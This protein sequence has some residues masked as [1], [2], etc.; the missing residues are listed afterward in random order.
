MRVFGLDISKDA[1]SCV[2]LET[3]F[4]RFEIRETYEATIPTDSAVPVDPYFTATGLLES[5]PGKPGRL[6]TSVPVEIST[7]RNIQVATKDKKSIR[8]ALNFELEDDLPFESDNLHYA[9]ATL[10]SAEPGSTIHVGA[11]KKD[12][13]ELH[14]QKLHENHIDPEIITTDAWAY[15]SLFSHIQ[16][17]ETVLLVGFEKSKT[18]FYVNGK[19]RPIL[20]REIPFGLNTLERKLGESLSGSKEELH[21]WIHDIGVTGIDETVSNSISDILE[22]LVPELKQIELSARSQV[23][24]PIDQILVTGAG[25]L[26][27]GFLTWLEQACQIQCSLF[28]PMSALTGA[29]VSY[30]D[31]SEVRFAKALGLAMA[32]IPTD[33]V[34]ALNL[35]TGPFIKSS[36]SVNSPLELIKKPLPYLLITALVLFGTKFTESNYYKTRLSESDDALKRAVKSYYSGISDSAART[37]L[38]DPSKLRKAVETE[39]AKEREL[40]KLFA[41]NPNSPLDFLKSLS[42][43]IG[44]DVV[45]DLVNF[46]A[47]SDYTDR[48][49]EKKPIRTSVSFLVSN[50]QSISKLNDILEKSFS[51][52][53][54]NS[55]ELTVEGR[56]V[57]RVIY[58]GMLGS[59]GK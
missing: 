34:P 23:K 1:V 47:G 33:K 9:Y 57:F 25:A 6:I 46:D 43:R 45:V 16:K 11:V 26:L 39:L 56:K 59:A 28:R 22:I 19:S 30:S 24:G 12:S 18:F 48:F 8:A 21:A 2:E 15:R 35:R 51:M 50:P 5:I 54:G 38:S 4:G 3:A 7:F 40:A 52:K 14:L 58:S 42:E 53:H 17:N 44:K 49:T 10:Q 36:S 27:P 41:P 37:Y 55:E 13:F 31:L 29:Q 20:Y 32:M